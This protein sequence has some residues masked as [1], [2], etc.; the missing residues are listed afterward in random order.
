MRVAPDSFRMPHNDGV[1]SQRRL[2][3]NA[4][5]QWTTIGCDG[6]VLSTQKYANTIA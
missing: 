3:E 6:L 5:G 1:K 2:G 4:T